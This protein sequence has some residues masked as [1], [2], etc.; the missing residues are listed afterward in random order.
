VALAALCVPVIIQPHV[1]S[2]FAD[3]LPYEQFSLRY[4]L[5][6]LKRLPAL[7]RAIPPRMLCTLRA[8]GARYGRLLTWQPPDGL[9]YDMLQL[10]LCRRAISHAGRRA[11][12][13]W[14]GACAHMTVDELLRTASRPT[15]F[16][17]K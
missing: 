13:A 14:D 4:G 5:S 3:L 7:L 8:N 15:P 1:Q 9:A 17:S 16:R 6:D 12:P 2:A 11:T 10:S